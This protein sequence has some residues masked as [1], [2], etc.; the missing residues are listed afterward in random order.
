[1]VNRKAWFLDQKHLITFKSHPL[2]QLLHAVKVMLH[3]S[4][5]NANLQRRFATHVFCTNLQTYYTFESLSKTS[6]ALQHCKYRKKSFATGR[7]TGMIFRATSYHCKLALQVDQ[8]N[9]TFT[10]VLFKICAFT[11]DTVDHRV[12]QSWAAT[13]TFIHSV[14]KHNELNV[15]IQSSTFAV[16]CRSRQ[17]CSEFIHFV[18]P[19]PLYAAVLH[20]STIACSSAA[21]HKRPVFMMFGFHRQI[22]EV[23]WCSGSVCSKT[24]LWRES[25]A[26][27][28]W[29]A[30][31]LLIQQQ[32]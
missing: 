10:L 22:S 9:I 19:T 32:S 21:G 5:C 4:T 12:T 31:V 29:T 15:L 18:Y 13:I 8:C 1:M 23:L 6:N 14:I 2:P 28:F 25:P 11:S 16:L 17:S 3:W 30:T 7:Y 26:S 24:K 27:L 20:V